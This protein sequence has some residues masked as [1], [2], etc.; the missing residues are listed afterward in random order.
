[1]YVSTLM[2]REPFFS[3]SVV[4]TPIVQGNVVID[5]SVPMVA[6][7]IVGSSMVEINEEDEPITNHEEEQQQPPIQDVLC[8]EPPRRS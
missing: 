7:L 5:S 3:V 8:N 2:V 4:V 6:M 1:V